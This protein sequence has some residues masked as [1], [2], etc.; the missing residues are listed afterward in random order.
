M[1][2]YE[3]ISKL[4]NVYLGLCCVYGS[5][6]KYIKVMECI[7]EFMKIKLRGK[8]VIYIFENWIYNICFFTVTMQALKLQQKEKG[9][10][11]LHAHNM[12]QVKF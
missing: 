9:K 6:W 5:I 4:W 1:E 7:T 2:V 3:S 10:T 11:D 12:P 8:R